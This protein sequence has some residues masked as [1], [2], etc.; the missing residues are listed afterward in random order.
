MEGHLPLWR[1]TEKEKEQAFKASQNGMSTE[2]TLEGIF[3]S[4]AKQGAQPPKG[5]TIQSRSNLGDTLSVSPEELEPPPKKLRSEQRAD[6]VPKGD[7]ARNDTSPTATTEPAAL[8]PYESHSK[9]YFANVQSV[10]APKTRTEDATWRLP[11]NTPLRLRDSYP[12]DIGNLVSTDAGQPVVAVQDGV[13]YSAFSS[14]DDPDL[15]AAFGDVDLLTPLA[16]IHAELRTL[17]IDFA[18]D[19]LVAVPPVEFSAIVVAEVQPPESSTQMREDSPLVVTRMDWPVVEAFPGPSTAP[20]EISQLGVPARVESSMGEEP[21]RSRKEKK[22]ERPPRPLPQDYG[23]TL[24]ST[25]PVLA[26]SFALVAFVAAAA[27]LFS[28]VVQDPD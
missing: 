15:F 19:T 27:I 4:T 3:A 18:R 16:T 2:G 17:T 24:D 7:D 1:R 20:I 13:A 6:V 10:Q 26:L 21:G 25:A 14:S 23:R 11:W 9:S 28:S 12:P 5:T 22:T 8:L